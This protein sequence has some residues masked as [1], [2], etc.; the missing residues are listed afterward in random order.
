MNS[1]VKLR[2]YPVSTKLH[3]I[4]DAEKIGNRA[5]GRKYGVSESCIRDWRKMKEKL[6]SARKCTRA[7]RGKSAKYPE[8]EKRLASYIFD[9]R[10]YAYAVSTEMA[11]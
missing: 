10:Q 4:C 6:L 1:E 9:R 8:I 5:A 2:S 7:F 3:I 11:K